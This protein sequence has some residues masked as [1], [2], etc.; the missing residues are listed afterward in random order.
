MNDKF[1][2]IVDKAI[3]AEKRQALRQ[4]RLSP[5]ALSRNQASG[6]SGPS[7]A[8]R[9]A[10]LWLGVGG[11]TVLLLIFSVFLMLQYK[12]Q[13]SAVGVTRQTIEQAF[14]HVHR[15]QAQPAL[16]GVIS[17][18]GPGNNS[19]MIWNIQ[20]VL[21]RVQRLQYSEPDLSDAIFRTLSGREGTSRTAAGLNEKVTHGLD[22]R[23]R[24]LSSRKVVAHVLARY[25]RR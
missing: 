24:Q 14:L 22:L 15:N 2:Q 1:D 7:A 20:S 12:K 25:S 4:F 10:L 18:D 6:V 5:I 8:L 11:T 17:L 23:I 16:P 9:P 3:E 19:D 13:P 21:Y